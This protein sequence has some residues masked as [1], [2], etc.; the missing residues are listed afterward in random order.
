MKRLP[1]L[2][3]MLITLGLLLSA[4]GGGGAAAAD[5]VSVVQTVMQLTADKKLDQLKNYA[6]AAEK[7]NV[8]GLFTGS[9]AE[10]GVDP[11]KLLDAMTIT[12]KD[13]TYNK[14]SEEGD[15]AVVAVKG[16]LAIKVD[17]EKF[18]P[19]LAEILKAQGQ[20]VPAEQLDQFV[21]LFAGQFEQDQPLDQNINLVK[22]NGQW[23]ICGAN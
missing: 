4:C 8:E 2:V 11:Q 6:C 19:V 12:L 21:S 1:L 13:V 9:M 5:P 22:E 7:D 14:V 20:E 15:K 17:A 10:L 18:K 23:L 16:Q 3:V